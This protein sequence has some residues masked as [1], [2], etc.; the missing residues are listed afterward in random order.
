MPM[1]AC[2]ALNNKYT[3]S[4]TYEEGWYS[5]TAASYLLQLHCLTQCVGR[6]L[7]MLSHCSEISDVLAA[8]S[9]KS[10]LKATSISTKRTHSLLPPAC[11]S[12]VAVSACCSEISEVTA[13]SSPRPARTAPY[14]SEKCTHSLL[15]T[16]C[17]SFVACPSHCSEISDVIA[18]SSPKSAAASPHSPHHHHHHHHHNHRC[19]TTSTSSAAAGA[20]APAYRCAPPAA[21][22][23]A[24]GYCF[25]RSDEA[26]LAAAAG[27][28]DRW[29]MHGSADAVPYV[30][31]PPTFPF[32]SV[33]VGPSAPMV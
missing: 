23:D 2:N 6:T 9:P 1:S 28:A 15:P 31:P 22:Q 33:P 21:G 32:Q 10:A 16:A 24:S 3:D 29:C 14:S 5:L 27:K 19:S 26:G 20:D 11:Y 30:K 8:S 12:Y 7:V 25:V 17:Y 18:A 4:R 13:A